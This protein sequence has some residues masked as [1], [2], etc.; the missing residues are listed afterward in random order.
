MKAGT[1]STKT[2][3]L[4]K[5]PMIGSTPQETI[6]RVVGALQWLNALDN[7]VGDAF[8][9]EPIESITFGRMLLGECCISALKATGHE[10][11]RGVVKPAP[12]VSHG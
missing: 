2:N 3:D 9:G 12:V 4:N 6:E 5:N 10:I 1:N 7:H 11:D 8:G